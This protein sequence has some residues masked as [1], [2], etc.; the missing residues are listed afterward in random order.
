[1]GITAKLK[2]L[3]VI[4]LLTCCQSCYDSPE[5]GSLII[6]PDKTSEK[7]STE[8]AKEYYLHFNKT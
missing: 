1:M 7:H 8:K 4:C 6:I 3:I 2:I 5:V